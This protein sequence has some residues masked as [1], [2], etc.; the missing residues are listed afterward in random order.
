MTQVQ[1]LLGLV[2]PCCRSRRA[3]VC[4]DR[5]GNGRTRGTTRVGCRRGIRRA[6]LPVLRVVVLEGVGRMVVE[7]VGHV[8]EAEIVVGEDG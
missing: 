8:R 6:A 4:R 7:R 3:P 1:G 5:N 2:T